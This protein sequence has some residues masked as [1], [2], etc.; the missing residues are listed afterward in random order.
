MPF[1]QLGNK[2][3]YKTG[4]ITST[5]FNALGKALL[6]LSTLLVTHYFGTTQNTDLVY[7]LQNTQVQISGFILAINMAVVI[8]RGVYLN[9]QN[10]KETTIAFYNA[11]FILYFAIGLI[12]LAIF[13]INPVGFIALISKF[14]TPFLQS[15]K[16]IL[17]FLP[18]AI[19]FNFLYQLMNDVFTS[20]RY[21]TLPVLINALYALIVILILV[22]F[23]K[24]INEYSY[25]AGIIISL[26]LCIL[27]QFI[28]LKRMGWHFSI[29]KKL[30]SVKTWWFIGYAQ[31]GQVFTLASSFLPFYLLSGETQG[32][33]TAYLVTLQLISLPSIFAIS[34]FSVVAGIKFT[35]YFAQNK[36]EEINSTFKKSVL[37]LLYITFP[38]ASLLALLGKDILPRFINFSNTQSLDLA[39]EFILLLALTIPANVVHT[40]VTRLLM[41]A[42]KLKVAFI[43]QAV[44]NSLL[45]IISYLLFKKVGAWGLPLAAL[46]GHAINLGSLAFIIKTNFRDVDFVY[47]IKWFLIIM[48]LNGILFFAFYLLKSFI[49]IN[50][51]TMALMSLLYIA[52]IAIIGFKIPVIREIIKVPLKF[53]KA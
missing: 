38:M 4:I 1:K 22:F 33:L 8:P 28:M 3:E 10:D 11:I 27:I 52:I 34:Q 32:A 25:P 31:L 47:V 2:Q 7:F 20:F 35:E 24:H 18:L 45:V 48:L 39:T 51:I 15:H 43:N 41:A 36:W 6:F 17:I 14:T 44:Q 19:L 16:S 26:L 46:I 37:F 29:N 50:L 53:L 30:I 5:A 42:Q 9:H 49:V 13:L 23:N 40:I 12:V 21:F